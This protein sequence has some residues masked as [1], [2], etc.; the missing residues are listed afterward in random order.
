MDGTQKGG[1]RIRIW[2][3]GGHLTK[4]LGRVLKKRNM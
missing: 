1:H 2:D 4:H 3:V